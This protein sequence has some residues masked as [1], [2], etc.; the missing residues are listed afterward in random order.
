METKEYI[1]SGILELYVYGVLTPEETEEVIKMAANHAEIK[2]EILSIEKAIVSLSFS[3]SPYLSAAN[4]SKI[5]NHLLQKQSDVIKIKS[6]ANTASYL[7]WAAAILLMVGIGILF[8]KSQ[9]ADDQLLKAETEKS[10]LKQDLNGLTIKNDTIKSVLAVVRDQNNIITP[11]DGQAI[12][13]LAKARI[14]WNKTTEI[15]YVD[16]SGLPEPPEGKEYQIW[17]LKLNPLTPTSIGL[18]LNYKTNDTKIFEVQKANGAQAFGIT[19]EPK[20]GSPSPTMEQLYALG[21]VKV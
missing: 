4:F 20:G 19:L 16:A 6:K 2:D 18:L 3:M 13:P 21:L 1:E 9:I 17:A 5:K 14:Y 8:N 12:A 10:K 15:V 7:G 11:L